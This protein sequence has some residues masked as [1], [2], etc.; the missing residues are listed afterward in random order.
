MCIFIILI[1]YY[2]DG[3]IINI[4]SLFLLIK[5]LENENRIFCY[6]KLSFPD[7][8]I[9]LY[10]PDLNCDDIPNDNFEVLPPDPH[11]FDR[12]EDGIGCET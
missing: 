3:K 8:C 11:G 1:L 6:N 5:I 9:A 7:I 4:N 2:N 10:P 12:E